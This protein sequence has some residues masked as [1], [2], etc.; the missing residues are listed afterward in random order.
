[1]RSKKFFLILSTVLFFLFIYFSFLVSKET[2][3]QIDFDT[4]HKLQNHISRK[5]DLPFSIFSILGSAEVTVLIWVLSCVVILLKRFWLTLFTLSLFF[6]SSAV[7]IFGKLFVFH[8]GPPHL[9]YRGVIQFD[10]PSSLVRTDYSY[11]SG[12]MTRTSFLVTFAIVAILFRSKGLK[13]TVV[14]SALIFTLLIMAVS[15]VYL[16]EHWL[17]DVIGGILLGSSLGIFT[18]LTIPLKKHTDINLLDNN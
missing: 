14:Q 16:G 11:P 6:V 15:R 3:T 12:H 8:P 7:E 17:S 4:T 13:A 5:F 10:L 2:F 9:F 1:M 18:S